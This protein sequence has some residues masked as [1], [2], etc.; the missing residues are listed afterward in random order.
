MWTWLE[1]VTRLCFVASYSVALLV[2]LIQ[3]AS[4]RPIPGSR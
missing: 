2:E 3:L 1:G 4:P